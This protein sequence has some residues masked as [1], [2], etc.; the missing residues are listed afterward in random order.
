MSS[1]RTQLAP[2]V[3]SLLAQWIFIAGPTRAACYGTPRSAI[4]AVVTRSFA[5]PVSKRGGYRVT[6]TL[7]DSVLGQ[8]W[9]MIASCDHPEWPAFALPVGAASIHIPQQTSYVL[10]ENPAAVVVRVGDVVHLWRQESLL[11]IEAAGI[12][13][14][15]GE[16]GKVVRVRLLHENTDGQS[17][18]EQ[19]FGI[20]R[21]PLDVEMQP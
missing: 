10:S 8:K 19:L 1:S 18:S 7:S 20:V 6:K 13:E 9:A 12:S 4:D 17:I 14:E 2:G 3:I 15:S 21:G 5:S 11:R 16:I